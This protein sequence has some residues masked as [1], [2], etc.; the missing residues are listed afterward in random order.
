[1]QDLKC[2]LQDIRSKEAVDAFQKSKVR[3]AIKGDE[4]SRVGYVFANGAFSI[5][6]NSSFIALIPKVV[7]DKHVSDFRPIS[8]IGASKLASQMDSSF[9]RTVRGGIE[10]AQFNDLVSFIGSSSLSPSFD[11][12]V[13]NI[14]GDG[15][16]RV[17]DFRNFIDDLVL[18][19][20]PEPTRWVKSIPI[21]INIFM[22]RA[23]RDC[24]STRANLTR[25]GVIMES[26]NCLICGSHEKD[27]HRIL[28]QCH[29]A[30]NVLRGLCRWWEL[31]WNSWFSFSSWDTWFRAIRIGSKI[32][33]LLEGVFCVAWWSIWAFRNRLLHDDKTPSRSTII[34]DIK[35]LS[36]L[37]CKNRCKWSFSLEDWLKTPHLISL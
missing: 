21:K 35:L 13:C 36:F 2:Q 4:N 6:C 27:V 17:K 33:S 16:F 23:R 37:W 31:D 14:S 12:W 19:S 32:K 1:R 5:G 26:V 3:W 18:P 15:N 22:W 11:R 10:L 25:R 9:R 20:S 29:L 24:L 7:D 30:Q 34:D 28:F 8:L